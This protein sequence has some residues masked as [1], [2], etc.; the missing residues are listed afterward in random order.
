MTI[1]KT[2]ARLAGTRVAFCVPFWIVD[3]DANQA[4]ETPQRG[5]SPRT[6]A[7]SPAAGN[8]ILEAGDGAPKIAV[9]APGDFAEIKFPKSN[10]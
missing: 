9:Q 10:A 5:A 6:A 8:G 1:G 2:S 4:A 3:Y 7:S